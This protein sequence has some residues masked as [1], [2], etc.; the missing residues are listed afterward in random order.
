MQ[1][2]NVPCPLIGQQLPV[3][4]VIDEMFRDRIAHW[5]RILDLFTLATSTVTVLATVRA[6]ALLAGPY[7][8]RVTVVEEGID[9]RRNMA[10]AYT[11]LSKLNR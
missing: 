9:P 1:L 11:Q 2:L 4:L 8:S 3:G 5:A 6:S 7:R 10:I